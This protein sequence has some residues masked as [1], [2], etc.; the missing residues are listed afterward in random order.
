[1]HEMSIAETIV[2]FVRDESVKYP[3][4]AIQ[5]VGVKIGELIAVVPESLQFCFD[6]IVEG[7]ELADTKLEIEI[8]PVIGHCEKCSIQIQPDGF[9][10]FCPHCSTP[11]ELEQGQELTIAYLEVNE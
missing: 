7:T 1:M 5:A 4:R 8:I 6:T 10:Y 3:V 9:N 2:D 11:L